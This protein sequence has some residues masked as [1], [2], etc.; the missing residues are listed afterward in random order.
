MVRYKRDMKV[1]FIF[2]YYGKSNE[3]FQFDQKIYPQ[4]KGA[5]KASVFRCKKTGRIDQGDI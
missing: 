1:S 5:D 2:Y 3:I 4:A